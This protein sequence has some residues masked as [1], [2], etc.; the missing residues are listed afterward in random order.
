MSTQ[1][2]LGLQPVPAQ[3]QRRPVTQTEIDAVLAMSEENQQER[4]ALIAATLATVLGAWAQVEMAQILT[5]WFRAGIGSRI[6]VLLSAAQ[7]STASKANGF[8]SGVYDA[9]G[10]PI[11]PPTVMP[12]AFSG[13][14]S[15]GR[16]LEGLLLGAPTQALQRLRRGDPAAVASRAAEDFLRAVVTTQI[17]DAGR[18]ADSVAIA[19]ARP[20]SP[21]RARQARR[22]QYGYVRILNPPSC[23]RCVVLA[24]R[25]YRWNQGF[26]RHPMCDCAHIPAIE[27]VSG[28]LR[29]DPMEYFNSLTEAEQNDAFGRANAQAI[30]DGA[31]ISQVVNA[32]TRGGVFV[33]DGSR[34][35]TRVGTTR[36]GTA[37]RRAPGV[38][39]PT[40]WQI[41]RDAAGDREEARRLLV[42]FGYIIR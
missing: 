37:G 2:G 36:R 25:F 42:Q 20:A 31:D 8:V 39:R 19:S 23:S 14:S 13:I 40:P 7:E 24:G 41:F 15:D 33:A 9:Y 29:T 4:A 38:L 32:T 28:D 22:S 26:L 6:F 16:D 17:A 34:R 1:P 12:S 27:D 10:R 18:A 3:Q 11:E 21:T 30:R 35:Y 5:S